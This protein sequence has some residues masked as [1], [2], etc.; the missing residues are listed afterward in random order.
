M[1]R[2]IIERTV[3]PGALDDVTD[4]QKQAVQ[5]N[6]A[7]FGVSWIHTYMSRDRTKTFCIYE[8]PDEEAI[9]EANRRNNIP[10]DRITEIPEDLMPA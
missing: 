3:P 10:V 4:E 5:A 9:R 7:V 6:N 8:G 2:Y 1:P